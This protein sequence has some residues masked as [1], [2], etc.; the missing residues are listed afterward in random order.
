MLRCKGCTAKRETWYGGF[1]EWVI[2]YEDGTRD[3]THSLKMVIMLI[4][5]RL[6]RASI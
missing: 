6:K 1:S 4:D 5:R 3:M 2:T